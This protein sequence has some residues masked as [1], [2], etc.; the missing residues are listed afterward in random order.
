MKT[1]QISTNGLLPEFMI[2]L[3]GE[4]ENLPTKEALN[5]LDEEVNFYVCDLNLCDGN[6]NKHN[7]TAWFCDKSNT[8]SVDFE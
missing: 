5:I 3:I 2:K 4:I 6:V 1:L 7:K 8:W